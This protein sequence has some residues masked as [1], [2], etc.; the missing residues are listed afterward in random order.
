MYLKYLV[1]YLYV[2]DHF[3][4]TFIFDKDFKFAFK[5]IW[6]QIYFIHKYVEYKI[7]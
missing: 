1:K 3:Y 4:F 2:I 7:L 5:N 6:L